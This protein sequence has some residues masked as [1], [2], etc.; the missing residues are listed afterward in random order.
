M[1]II[2]HPE[3][4]GLTQIHQLRGRVGRGSK[5]GLCVLMASDELSEK[6]MSRLEIP[7]KSHDGFEIAQKDLEL[8]GQGELTGTRQAGAGELDYPDIINEPELFLMAKEA[9]ERLITADPE[10][11]AP[12]HQALRVMVSK[13]LDAPL[14]L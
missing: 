12:G 10:L 11:L 13:L 2:E 7:V 14:D 6:S 5:R 8:R 9:A 3:R 1:M 4:F